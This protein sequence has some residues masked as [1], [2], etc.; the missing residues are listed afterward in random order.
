MLSLLRDPRALLML[1]ESF[2]KRNCHHRT[3]LGE[4]KGQVPGITGEPRATCHARLIMEVGNL[5]GCSHSS[6]F[7]GIS[8][9]N[10]TSVIMILCP[11]SM[12]G[13]CEPQDFRDRICYLIASY[14]ANKIT[15]ICQVVF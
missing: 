15:I 12:W 11:L 13:T 2:L 5:D 9:Q 3:T 14:G 7:G 8:E 1:F 10:E 6:F 4:Q